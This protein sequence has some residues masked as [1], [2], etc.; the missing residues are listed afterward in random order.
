[1]ATQGRGRPAAKKAAPAKVADTEVITPQNTPEVPTG[2]APGAPTSVEETPEQREIRELKEQVQALMAGLASKTSEEAPKTEDAPEEGDTIVIHF[3][4]DGH[5]AQGQVWYR[6]Q[7]LEFI[8]GSKAWN[9]TLDRN[10][11]S[12]VL[13]SESDQADKWNAVKYRRGPWTGKKSYKDGE[14]ATPKEA[15]AES[16]LEQADIKE[17]E[18]RLKG[19]P[20]LPEVTAN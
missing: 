17:R 18:R 16:V 15:P 12:W 4:E 10:G 1:M 2:P 19:A 13:M 9:D 8:V 7:E 6:G 5:T 11:D 3:I 20:T 14:W